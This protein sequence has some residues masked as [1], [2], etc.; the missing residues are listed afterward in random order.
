MICI[1]CNKPLPECVC[2]DLVEMLAHIEDCA[3]CKAKLSPKLLDLAAR[4]V[5]QNKRKLEEGQQSLSA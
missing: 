3:E 2:P 5:K 1:N 4:L